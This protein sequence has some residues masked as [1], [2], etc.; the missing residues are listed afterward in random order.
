MARSNS[1]VSGEPSLTMM[2]SNSVRVWENTESS[3][4]EM[5][6]ATWYAGIMTLTKGAGLPLA[7]SIFFTA[8]PAY[9][10]YVRLLKSK[11]NNPLKFLDATRKRTAP[12]GYW[13]SSGNEQM[14]Q[15]FPSRVQDWC[16][17]L[18]SLAHFCNTAFSGDP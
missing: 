15:A 4:S 8:S 11:T 6:G 13:R 7:S 18:Y 10:L 1:S 12:P 16:E 14:A 17:R 9:N 5:Y 2:T 3:V